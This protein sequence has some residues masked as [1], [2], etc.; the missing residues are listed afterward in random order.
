MHD[1]LRI[2]GHVI[3]GFDGRPRTCLMGG[4]SGG[5]ID[6]VCL[7][8]GGDELLLLMRMLSR[9]LWAYVA[10][11]AGRR[12]RARGGARGGVV[13]DSGPLRGGHIIRTVVVGRALRGK[14]C[15][16]ILGR[17]TLV[18]C[19][20][21]NPMSEMR[22]NDTSDAPMDP[23]GMWGAGVTAAYDKVGW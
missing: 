19:E 8:W 21:R 18:G 15:V 5:R 20:E 16:G 17:Q 23:A 4:R 6:L 1:V 7:R 22:V 13:L 11:G 2:G 10:R 12:V 14:G 9:C 3:V